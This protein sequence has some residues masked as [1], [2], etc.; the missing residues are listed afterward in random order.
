MIRRQGR[1]I[2]ADPIG[3]EGGIN[4]FSYVGN[5]PINWVDQEGLYRKPVHYDDTKDLAE[6]EGLGPCASKIAKA[7]Q[8]VDDNWSTNP[9]D[10]SSWGVWKRA[11]W[12]FPTSQG[13]NEVKKIAL[14]SCDPTYLGMALHVLQ[15]SFS[16]AGYPAW[17]GHIPPRGG[18]DPD[19]P[20]NYPQ[21]YE[22]MKNETRKLLRQFKEKCGCCK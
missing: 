19:D 12:H 4:L 2:T 21:K 14:Q 9:T 22:D 17:R 15:D 18:I 16:H 5:D 8:G 20:K 7:D 1:Y 3:L 6:K 13:V 10:L 11:L